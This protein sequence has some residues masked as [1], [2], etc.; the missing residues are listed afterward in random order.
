MPSTSHPCPF[1]V[2]VVLG[3]WEAVRALGKM[4]RV[5]LTYWVLGKE[6]GN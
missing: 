3:V 6:C 4:T 5:V 1:L 2:V